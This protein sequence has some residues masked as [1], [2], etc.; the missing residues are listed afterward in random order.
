MI[1]SSKKK[2]NDFWFLSDEEQRIFFTGT[3][4]KMCLFYREKKR[5]NS[6]FRLLRDTNQI[7]F[8][9]LTKTKIQS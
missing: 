4:T 3:T 9:T 5:E 8:F 7:N 1:S 6:D 2:F